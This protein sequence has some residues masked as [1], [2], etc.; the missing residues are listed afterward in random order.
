MGCAPFKLCC[1]GQRSVQIETKF[2]QNGNSNN[3]NVLDNK[4]II[5]ENGL[6]KDLCESI[7]NILPIWDTTDLQQFKDYLKDKTKN[8]NDI[9][10]AFILFLWVCNNIIYDT[11]SYFARRKS[12]CDP[13]AVLKME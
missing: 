8:V 2:L 5:N 7:Y 13:E 12:N 10:N 1:S 11:E 3:S 4:L 9:N 6:D